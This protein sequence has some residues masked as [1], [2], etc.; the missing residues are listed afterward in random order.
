MPTIDLEAARKAERRAY[1][2]GLKRGDMI[3]CS[4]PM[5]AIAMRCDGR[6]RDF[7]PPRSA[8]EIEAARKAAADKA[9]ADKVWKNYGLW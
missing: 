2:K 6:L 7:S 9:W 1:L 3:Q 5:Q 4:L 8:A